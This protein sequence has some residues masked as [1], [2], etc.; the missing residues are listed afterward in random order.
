VFSASQCQHVCVCVCMHVLNI[1][2]YMVTRNK[3][4]NVALRCICMFIPAWLRTELGT[5]FNLRQCSYD[6]MLQATVSSMYALTYHSWYSC[7]IVTKFWLSQQVLTKVWNKK[8][9]INPF[10]GSWADTQQQT[11]W[12]TGRQ[13]ERHHKDSKCFL[14]VRRCTQKHLTCLC[15]KP[16]FLA[17]VNLETFNHLTP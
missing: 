17:P 7:L 13:R 10:S 8:L 9:H 1:L 15:Y 16:S 11:D 12:L 3:S 6:F 14:K 4:G 5:H 2:H